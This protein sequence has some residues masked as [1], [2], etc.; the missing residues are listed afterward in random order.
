[1][2]I[3]EY[4]SGV[5]GVTIS[6]IIYQQKECD[7]LLVCKIISDIVW[8]LQFYSTGK[9]TA[10]V[11][12]AVAVFRD[13][14]FLIHAKKNKKVGVGWLVLFMTLAVSS[15]FVVLGDGV[16]LMIPAPLSILAGACSALSAFSFWL[17]VPRYSRRIA[18]PYSTGMIIYDIFGGAGQIC[19][20]GLAN[21]SFTIIS[22][23]IG[24]IRLDLLF[25]G[26]EK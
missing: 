22:S 25:S 12:S 4:V 15:S 2:E 5:L 20:F 14:I 3:L 16:S 13:V 21:E 11:M 7:K 23:I 17:G 26:R 1:M 10:A 19:W 6:I 24:I 8:G 18:F 9:D